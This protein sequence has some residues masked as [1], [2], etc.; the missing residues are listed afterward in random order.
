MNRKPDATP[1]MT[2]TEIQVV[3]DRVNARNRAD[4][5]DEKDGG[6]EESAF[7]VRNRFRKKILG[8]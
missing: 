3:L 2:R 4:S 6:A 1:P 8:Q 7:Q 5:D